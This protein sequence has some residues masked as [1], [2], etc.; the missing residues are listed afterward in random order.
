[1]NGFSNSGYQTQQDMMNMSGMS[2]GMSQFGHM[3]NCGIGMMR[4]SLSG[5]SMNMSKAEMK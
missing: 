2:Q 4:R 5:G 3:N 1:M